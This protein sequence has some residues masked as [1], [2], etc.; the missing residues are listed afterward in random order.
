MGIIIFRKIDLQTPPPPNIH[1]TIKK[2][3]KE[4]A[5]VHTMIYNTRPIIDHKFISQNFQT[6]LQLAIYRIADGCND[7]I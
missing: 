2:K 1:K 6:A 4:K 5:K 7:P 3:K